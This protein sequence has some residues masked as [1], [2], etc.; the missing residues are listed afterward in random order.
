[1]ADN[2]VDSITLRVAGLGH[3]LTLT[4]APD[5]TILSLK[6]KIETQTTLPAE[7]QRLICHGKNLNDDSVTVHDLDRTKILLVHSAL[8]NQDKDSFEALQKLNAEIKRSAALEDAD[9]KSELAT[10]I[11]CKLDAIDIHDSPTLR[12]L[13]K[14]ALQAAEALDREHHTSE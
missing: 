4:L 13:R 10:Q 12:R 1:M 7:Y 3:K 8:Y 11:C 6:N 9:L 14:A 5:E 2:T